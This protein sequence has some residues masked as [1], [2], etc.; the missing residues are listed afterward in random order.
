MLFQTSQQAGRVP[1]VLLLGAK[2]SGKSEFLDALLQQ[3]ALTASLVL[4]EV[5]GG[6]PDGC[7]CCGM[8][9]GLGDALRKIFFEALAD[10][11]KRLHRVFLVSQDI[12]E[13]QLTQTLRHTPFL[14]QRYEHQL[15]FRL[16]SVS[17][18]LSESPQL[19]ERIRSLLGLKADRGKSQQFLVL[20]DPEDSSK[21][22]FAALRD[23]V[24][25]EF[26]DQQVLRFDTK[27]LP[28]QLGLT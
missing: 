16:L 6:Q 9:S 8:H 26:P 10:R 4:P 2:G 7:L 13:A 17:Q 1:L 11:Q 18:H 23:Q 24:E 15:T 20:V 12:T 22:Q 25:G 21:E 5:R 14:G 28:T 3:P 27:S 19:L